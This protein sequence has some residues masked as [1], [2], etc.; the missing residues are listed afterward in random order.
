MDSFV[1][2]LNDTRLEGA[3]EYLV[4]WV[5]GGWKELK[6]REFCVERSRSRRKGGIMKQCW[7]VD[8][9]PGNAEELARRLLSNRM[10]QFNI[11][12]YGIE[13]TIRKV[14]VFLK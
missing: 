5:G 2:C 7:T 6:N 9:D 10:L 1:R 11:Q 3:I 4:E 14:L 13:R 12:L 8:V